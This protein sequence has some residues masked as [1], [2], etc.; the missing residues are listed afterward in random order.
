M[1][2]RITGYN[3]GGTFFE[4]IS[5]QYIFSISFFEDASSHQWFGLQSGGEIGFSEF[6]P[7]WVKVV[8]CKNKIFWFSGSDVCKFQEGLMVRIRVRVEMS[9]RLEVCL[10]EN[11]E[12]N[13]LKICLKRSL[14]W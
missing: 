7:C 10:K 11:S 8:I 4:I 9:N 2:N 1:E 5:S 6:P 12:C 13:M 14:F 3:F